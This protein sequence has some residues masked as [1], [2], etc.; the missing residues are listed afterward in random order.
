MSE[1]IVQIFQFL[2]YNSNDN[3][4]KRPAER[5]IRMMGEGKNFRLS[6][7]FFHFQK[8]RIRQ[9][10]CSK[11]MMNLNRVSWRKIPSKYFD[12]NA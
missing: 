9:Q 7:S 6:K 11:A 8:R 2:N 1:H 12:L 5:N 4:P 3:F 10:F